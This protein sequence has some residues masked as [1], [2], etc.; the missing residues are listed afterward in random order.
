MTSSPSPPS[1]RPR[2]IHLQ[3]LFRDSILLQLLTYILIDRITLCQ[4]LNLTRYSCWIFSSWTSNLARV[5]SRG[6]SIRAHRVNAFFR[7]LSQVWNLTY[8]T[9]VLS[10]FSF[11]RSRKSLTRCQELF[12]NRG[13][14]LGM[15]VCKL[16]RSTASPVQNLTGAV[17][18]AEGYLAKFQNS[19]SV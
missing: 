2:K 1:S 6:Q 13:G 7:P 18:A 10:T 17:F 4:P 14:A 16:W 19:C 12:T 11:E 9:W 3:M 15:L 5:V 8:A